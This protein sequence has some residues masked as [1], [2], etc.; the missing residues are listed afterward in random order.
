MLLPGAETFTPGLGF[1]SGVSAWEAEFI[2]PC[3]THKN[4]DLASENGCMEGPVKS[5]K[6]EVFPLQAL[7]HCLLT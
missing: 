4:Q 1:F 5:M 2:N 3:V 7:R 6:G